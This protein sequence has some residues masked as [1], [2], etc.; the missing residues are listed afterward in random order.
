M[1]FFTSPSRY[2]NVIGGDVVDDV[3][4]GVMVGGLFGD[5]TTLY[6]RLECLKIVTIKN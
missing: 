6:F 3:V 2:V 4:G 5:R 1:N